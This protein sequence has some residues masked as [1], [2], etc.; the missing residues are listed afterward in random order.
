MSHFQIAFGH[1]FSAPQRLHDRCFQV[2]RMRH[3]I[4]RVFHVEHSGVGVGI[5]KMFHVGSNFRILKERRVPQ[6]Q[7]Y[8]P[9]DEAKT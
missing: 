6:A 5:Q 4:G 7:P 8:Q 2:W 1:G 9:P 3:K